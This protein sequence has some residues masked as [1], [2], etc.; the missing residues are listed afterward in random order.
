[1]RINWIFEFPK[2]TPSDTTTPVGMFLLNFC[3]KFQK[4]GTKYLN[5]KAY[6]GH[7]HLNHHTCNFICVYYVTNTYI[8]TYTFI[9]T[10]VPKSVICSMQ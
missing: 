7:S 6:D 4:L 2:H 5:M 3:P 8:H 9:I 10:T 1:M